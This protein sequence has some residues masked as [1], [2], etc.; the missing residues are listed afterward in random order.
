MAV[1]LST[2]CTVA[3]YSPKTLFLCLWYSF[4]LETDLIRS[5]TR[6]LPACSVVP[7]SLLP[8]RN[9]LKQVKNDLAILLRLCVGGMEVS[10]QIHYK[11]YVLAPPPQPPYKNIPV[12]VYRLVIMSSRPVSDF[13][14]FF[15]FVAQE[16]RCSPVLVAFILTLG[17]NVS[18]SLS[19]SVPYTPESFN[20]PAVGTVSLNIF[21][22]TS[23]F[24][25]VT[26]FHD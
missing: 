3:L 16:E 11:Q 18:L 24:F 5:R 26:P 1:R 13:F 17:T 21:R 22:S 14:L 2:L 9:Y 20:E 25:S 10:A 7:K 6:D 4:L 19:L 15:F 12:S 8:L 23:W